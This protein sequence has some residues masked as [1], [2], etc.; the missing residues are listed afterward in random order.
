VLDPSRDAELVQTTTKAVTKQAIETADSSIAVLPF[1]NMSSDPEQQYFSD[2]IS[3]ELLN[4]LVDVDGL[5]VASRTSSFSYRGENKNLEEIAD[6]LSVS[7][8]LEGSVRK[9]GNRVRITAQLIEAATDRHLWSEIYERDLTDIFAMQ[10]EI[11]NAIVAALR[12]SLKIEAA[13]E[14]SV[15]TATTNMNAYELFLEARELFTARAD[16]ER[17][18]TLFEQA[19]ALDPGFAR[20]WEGLSAAYAIMPSWG[21][22]GR[23]YFNLALEA[24]QSALE[25]D[26]SLSL[27]YSVIGFVYMSRQP[28]RWRD[29]FENFGLAAENGSNDGTNFLWQARSYMNLGYFELAM[30]ALGQCLSIDPQ[31]GNCH[32]HKAMLHLLR[33]ERD[34][35]IALLLRTLESGVSGTQPLF[36]SAFA[37]SGNRS[38]ALIL[39]ERAT[40]HSGAPIKEWISLIENPDMDRREALKAF[41]R[42]ID[43]E[44]IDVNVGGLEPMVIAFGAFDRITHETVRIYSIWLPEFQKYRQSPQFKRVVDEFEMQAFWRSN[45]FPPQ[46]RP[47]GDDDFECD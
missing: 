4:V 13:I 44:N 26:S 21:N 25:F 24:A 23:D 10:Q 43:R 35:G 45:G 29:S 47:I 7:Y 18:I 12:E 46:C 37:L 16:F 36:V 2:G 14:I 9:A 19:V 3:E 34:E 15:S 27:A 1:V 32:R 38:S 8:V 6:A 17:S 41:D 22:T 33:G 42:W 5:R 30:S 11:A 20:A 31:Y 40:G 28:Y 39:A